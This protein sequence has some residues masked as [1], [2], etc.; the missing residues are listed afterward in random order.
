MSLW[1]FLSDW[2]AGVPTHGALLKRVMINAGWA[3]VLLF[4][5]MFFQVPAE[6]A[7]VVFYGVFV[8]N[9]VMI[10]VFHRQRQQ[11]RD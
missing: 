2:F 10:F 6:Y 11:M 3:I 9:G 4:A 1:Y 8:V 5:M 7:A